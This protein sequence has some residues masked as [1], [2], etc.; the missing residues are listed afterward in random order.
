MLGKADHRATDAQPHSCSDV[1]S[2][3]SCGPALCAVRWNQDRMQLNARRRSGQRDVPA[4][5]SIDRNADKLVAPA[6]Q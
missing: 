5:Y 4:Q 3:E 6:S 1:T 2:T